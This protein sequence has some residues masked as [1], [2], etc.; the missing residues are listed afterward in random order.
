MIRVQLSPHHPLLRGAKCAVSISGLHDSRTCTLS[1]GGPTFLVID[2]RKVL[3]AFC[4]Y[5]QAHVHLLEDWLAMKHLEI[6]FD[7]ATNSVWI[8][9]VGPLSDEDARD[10][11]KA[12]GSILGDGKKSG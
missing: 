3:E 7:S 9:Y 10:A 8:S 12:S 4:L 2:R 5:T 6:N 11:M 1:D